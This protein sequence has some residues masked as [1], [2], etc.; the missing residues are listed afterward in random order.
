MQSAPKK[1]LVETENEM[2]E[3]NEPAEYETYDE[4]E[5][6]L[7]RIKELSDIAESTGHLSERQKE[8]ATML[9]KKIQNMNPGSRPGMQ[10]KGLLALVVGGI[11]KVL[12]K[13]GVQT[14]IDVIKNKI[15]VL[16]ISSMKNYFSFHIPII[17]QIVIFERLF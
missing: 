3:Q 1:Y 12:V 16:F 15:K 8:E 6:D 5:S 4:Y 17:Y 14:G 13:A 11:V 7:Q 2:L 10:N 9:L